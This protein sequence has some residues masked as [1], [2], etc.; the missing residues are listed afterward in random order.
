L[1]AAGSGI[2]QQ[3]M[4][5]S[6]ATS[7]ARAYSSQWDWWVEFINASYPPLN[8]NLFMDGVDA[9]QA[10]LVVAHFVGYLFQQ[11]MRGKAVSAK[12]TAVRQFYLFHCKDTSPF[13]NPIVKQVKIGAGLSVEERKVVLRQK[14]GDIKLPVPYEFVQQMRMKYHSYLSS[15]E[16]LVKRGIYLACALCFDTGCRISNVTHK[17]SSTSNDHCIRAGEVILVCDDVKFRAGQ[18]F[19]THFKSIMQSDTR[20]ISRVELTFLTHKASGKLSSVPT[21]NVIQRRNTGESQLVDDLVCWVTDSGVQEADE[22]LSRYYR[23]RNRCLLAKDVI[24]AMKELSSELGI[25]P[26]HLGT[27]GCRKGFATT[28]VAHN[29]TKARGGWSAS[30]SVMEDLYVTPVNSSGGFALDHTMYSLDDMFRLAQQPLGDGG[31][32]GC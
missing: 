20:R 3:L 30:S 10:K 32:S 15:G 4:H 23:G 17:P 12:V 8:T 7:T 25:S 16:A 2:I 11:G 13:D 18:T 21:P 1:V 5:R 24:T 19:R 6:V 31:G 26:V 29:E 14:S 27:H 28:S 22:F 9:Q